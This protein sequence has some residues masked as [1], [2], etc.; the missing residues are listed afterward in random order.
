MRVTIGDERGWSRRGLPNGGTTCLAMDRKADQLAAGGADGSIRFAGVKSA[1][2]DDKKV[3][4]AHEG[5]VRA[6]AFDGRGKR[7]VSAGEDGLLRVWKVSNGRSELEIPLEA[8]ARVLACDPKGRWVAVGD[9]EGA[10]RL[11]E[12]K[13][14]ELVAILAE[15]TGVFCAGVAFLDKGRALAA[16]GDKHLRLWDL[17]GADL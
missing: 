6:L 2:V 11:Y 15:P 10:G 8:D 5:K 17:G 13:K 12:L 16:A 3:F 9:V 1:N 14:G 4:E 7:I